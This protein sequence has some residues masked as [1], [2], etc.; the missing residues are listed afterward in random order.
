MSMDGEKKRVSKHEN[1]YGN[2]FGLKLNKRFEQ[3]SKWAV[4]MP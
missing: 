2:S 3:L 4:T 1:V